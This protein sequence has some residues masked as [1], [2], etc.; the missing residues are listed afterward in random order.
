VVR[1]V[2]F[3]IYK[4]I[5]KINTDTANEIVKKKSKIPLGRGI[6]IIKRIANTKN[7]TPKS[8]TP[9]IF[10]LNLDNFSSSFSSL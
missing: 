7:T 9:P 8:L 10:S 4:E 6:I 1:S 5:S 2:G 3:G